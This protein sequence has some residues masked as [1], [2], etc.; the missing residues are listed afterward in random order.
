MGML[1]GVGMGVRRTMRG[2]CLRGVVRALGQLRRSES[3][4][5]H[6]LTHGHGIAQQATKDQQQDDEQGKQATHEGS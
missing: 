1:P 2:R 6:H 3:R 4:T 5:G